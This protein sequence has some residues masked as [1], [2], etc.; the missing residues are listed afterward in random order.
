MKVNFLSLKSEMFCLQLV[1]RQNGQEGIIIS[2]NSRLSLFFLLLGEEGPE[3]SYFSL[4][5]QGR[6]GS[7]LCLRFAQQGKVDSW[8]S[9]AGV[10]LSLPSDWC[11]QEGDML[12]MAEGARE[13][14]KLQAR[15][16]MFSSQ[17]SRIWVANR[18]EAA[19]SWWWP[20]RKKIHG[21]T[22]SNI[23]SDIFWSVRGKKI[24]KKCH[25]SRKKTGEGKNILAWVAGA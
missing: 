9:L 14:S 10:A 2:C 19:L 6:G 18:L 16:C 13:G 1:V 23:C 4:F 3:M 20:L 5:N 8:V 25:Y 11:V 24:L 7:K 12:A 21:L 17:V 15:H 22:T